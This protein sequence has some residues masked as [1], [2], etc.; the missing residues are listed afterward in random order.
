[1]V[2]AAW[3]EI[4]LSCQ[5]VRAYAVCGGS[6]TQTRMNSASGRPE[7]SHDL[8]LSC[9]EPRRPL[10]GARA[11][12]ATGSVSKLSRGPSGPGPALP[13]RRPH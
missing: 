9:V 7:R 11:A 10:A 3:R 4:I 12:R 2:R 5:W 1:M 6:V 8:G 13:A